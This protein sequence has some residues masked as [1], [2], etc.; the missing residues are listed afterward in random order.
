MF[1]IGP[2][3]LVLGLVYLVSALVAWYLGDTLVGWAFLILANIWIAK[4]T[5]VK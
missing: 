2:V 3:Y 5:V 1:W 4:S